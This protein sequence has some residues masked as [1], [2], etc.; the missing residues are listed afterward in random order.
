M[1]C[2]EIPNLE[3]K[4]DHVKMPLNQSINRHMENKFYSL[5]SLLLSYL[6]TLPLAQDMTQGQFLSGV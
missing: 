3:I 1:L 5:L 6:P 4:N 2:M